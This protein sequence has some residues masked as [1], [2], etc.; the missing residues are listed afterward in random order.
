MVPP[1]TWRLAFLSKKI[2]GFLTFH[3]QI[4]AIILDGVR[5]ILK[6]FSRSWKEIQEDSWSSWQE[7]QE[8]VRYWQEKQESLA[9]M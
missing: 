2:L 9:S 3:T 1:S 5:K 7:N 8:S 6:D 4:L